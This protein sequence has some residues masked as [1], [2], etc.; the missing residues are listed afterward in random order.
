[1]AHSK[2]K[3]TADIREFII[4]FTFEWDEKKANENLKRHN[5]SFDEA[6][7]VFNDPFS[8][9]IYDPD[10]SATE[11]RY[12]D[13]GLSSKG[14]LIVVSYVER[15]KNTRIISSRKATKKEQRHYEKK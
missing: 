7:T 15:D 9:T 4:L 8:I 2:C 10:H 1:M 3:K 12:I 14:K 13:I 11:H 6:K 5:I